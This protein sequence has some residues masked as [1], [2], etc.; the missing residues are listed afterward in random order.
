MNNRRVNSVGIIFIYFFLYDKYYS[1]NI[2]YYTYNTHIYKK[3]IFL[4]VGGIN[5]YI[6]A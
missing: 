5:L 6:I 2:A 3:T 1:S 4:D